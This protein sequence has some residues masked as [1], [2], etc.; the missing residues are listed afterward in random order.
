MKKK[1]SHPYGHSTHMTYDE[2]GNPVYYDRSGSEIHA[3]EH[4]HDTAHELEQHGRGGDTILAH[5]NADEARLLKQHGGS[6][7]INPYTGLMEFEG[8]DGGGDGGDGGD[9]TGDSDGGIGGT[10]GSGNSGG[11]DGAD[12]GDTGDTGDDG[13]IDGTVGSGNDG[14]DEGAVSGESN[15]GDTGDDGSDGS[16]GGGGDTGS[17]GGD[18]GGGDGGGPSDPTKPVTPVAPVVVPGTAVSGVTPGVMRQTGLNPGMMAPTPFYNTTNDTQAKYYWGSHPMQ[19]GS[20]FDAAAYNNVPGAPAQA[21]GNQP[22]NFS[23]SP[24]QL[25]AMSESNPYMPEATTQQAPMVSMNYDQQT[26][27]GMQNTLSAPFGKNFYSDIMNHI[28]TTLV[29]SPVPGLDLSLF[30]PKNYKSQSK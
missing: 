30:D 2:Y 14:G 1:T 29:G 18:G 10:A 8:G 13:G 11:D 24:E 9:G 20:T 4:I 3:S 6:G 5:I 16:D 7:A 12:S 22:N 27:P 19:T 26:T 23:I 28:V 15:T 25:T 21:W 17:G